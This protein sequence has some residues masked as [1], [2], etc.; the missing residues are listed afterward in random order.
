MISDIQNIGI[1][2]LKVYDVGKGPMTKPTSQLKGRMMAYFKLEPDLLFLFPYINSVAK[3]AELYE[4]PPHIKFFFEDV[5]CILHPQRCFV[6]PIN[7]R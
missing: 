7:D 2:K 1:T 5:L 6:S 4:T 3:Q